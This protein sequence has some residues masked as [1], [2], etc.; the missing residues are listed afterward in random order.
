VASGLVHTQENSAADV[1]SV[2]H[3]SSTRAPPV[4]KFATLRLSFEF[5]VSASAN[6][7]PVVV[8][9]LAVVST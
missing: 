5:A 4:S 7:P 2:P 9:L 6:V 8:A 1:S 3:I